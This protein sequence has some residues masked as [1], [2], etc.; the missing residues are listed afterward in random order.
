MGCKGITHSAQWHNRI[1]SLTLKGSVIYR[2]QTY[3]ETSH[4]QSEDNRL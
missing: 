1:K 3:N 2:E 4:C